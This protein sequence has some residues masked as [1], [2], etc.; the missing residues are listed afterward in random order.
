[1]ATISTRTKMRAAGTT[2]RAAGTAARGSMK[3]A[4]T[5]VRIPVKAARRMP[6]SRRRSVSIPVPEIHFTHGPTLEVPIPRVEA[7]HARRSS[8]LRTLSAAGGTAAIVY[9]LDPQ[10]GR[11]RRHMAR[12]R[13][14]KLLRQA[15][16]RAERQARYAAGVQAGKRAEQQPSP[17]KPH[18]DQPPA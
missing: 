9:L 10:Q 6:R 4:G 11:R 14:M 3:A 12:D 8:R 17:P 18:E 7:E 5:A 13:G 1:M 15:R 2:M 16:R